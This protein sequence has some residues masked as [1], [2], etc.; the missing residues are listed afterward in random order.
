[1][2]SMTG[3]EFESKAHGSKEPVPADF[4]PSFHGTARTELRTGRRSSRRDNLKIAR[5]FNAGFGF[6]GHSSPGGTAERTQ[7]FQ[8]SLRDSNHLV[9]K[10]GV[11]T[12][13]YYQRSRWDQKSGALPSGISHRSL[14]PP[15]AQPRN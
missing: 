9:L 7:Q 12:P 4:F 8:P 15:C 3:G 13:G 14:F 6:T 10:P 5:C 11:E 1:M 2:K